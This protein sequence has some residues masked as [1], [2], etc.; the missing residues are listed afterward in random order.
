MGSRTSS[1]D[2]EN[3]NVQGKRLVAICDRTLLVAFLSVLIGGLQSFKGNDP[4]LWVDLIFDD[5][6]YYLGVAKNML[7]GFGSSYA[8]PFLTNGYQPL[9]LGVLVFSGYVF[10]VED[11]SLVLQ[12]YSLCYFLVLAYS[13]LSFKIHGSVAPALASAFM[14]PSVMLQGM[15]TALLPVLVVAYFKYGKAWIVKGVLASLIFLSRL[16]ALSLIV[17]YDVYLKLCGEKTDAFH[18]VLTLPIVTAYMGVNYFIFG[19]PVPVSGL[20]KA[21]GNHAG[22]N[23]MPLWQFADALMLPGSLLSL[24]VALRFLFGDKI[25]RI[26]REV[27][28]LFLVSI[29]N[30]LYYH[31][32]SGWR[33]WGWYL[34]PVV[35]LYYYLI[36]ALINCVIGYG[37][38]LVA[39]GVS[40]ISMVVILVL[41]VMPVFNAAISKW[42]VRDYESQVESWGM[43]NIADVEYINS[44]FEKGAFFAMGDRSGSFGFF[45]GNDFRFLQ[46][47]GL[48]ASVEYWRALQAGAGLEFLEKQNIDYFIV[49]RNHVFEDNGIVGIPEPI[50]GYSAHQGPYLICFDNKSEL[51]GRKT[52]SSERLIYPWRHRVA[53][54][55]EM[56]VVFEG[57]R[58]QYGGLHG[59]SYPAYRMPQWGDLL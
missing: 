30:A 27:W 49:D 50:M 21:V 2:S 16:D 43:R 12:C 39:K 31:F 20:V 41:F 3:Q 56:Q 55:A 10:G 44:H 47:E 51:F 34:W 9:W 35:I 28:V 25:P 6:Y 11:R 32:F 38:S 52:F 40:I 13:F 5:A 54:P 53:C 17:L 26:P 58:N 22:E 24:M 36:V 19:I 23:F 37:D 7:L 15:E 57:L 59:F 1:A 46:T 33:L 14:I 8:P 42:R 48:V 29:C 45:L 4:K 18:W